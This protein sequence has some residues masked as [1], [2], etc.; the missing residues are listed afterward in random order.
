MKEGNLLSHKILDADW[1]LIS[2][3]SSIVLARIIT[4]HN[5]LMDN[6]LN[7]YYWYGAQYLEWH[8]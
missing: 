2:F 7:T 1:D 8:F 3:A 4:A 5:S 6:G